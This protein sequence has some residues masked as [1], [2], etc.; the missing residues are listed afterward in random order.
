MDDKVLIKHDDNL[1]E[2]IVRKM[3]DLRKS[4]RKVAVV[5]LEHPAAVVDMTLAAL[6]ERAGVSE[7][8]AIR[9]CA[10]I[11]CNGFRDMRVRLA[12]SLAFARSSSHM[13]VAEDD[14]LQTLITKI[15]DY[16][17]AS[18]NWAQGRLDLQKVGAA[19]EI[20]SEARR[21][22]FFGFGASGIVA[23]D[24]Q[25]KFPLFDTPCG[26]TSD[27]HQMFMTAGM[28]GD[29]DVVVAI[30]NTGTTREVVQAARIAQEN[31]AR[32]IGIT[33]FQSA[34]VRHCDVA[35]IVETLENTDLYT[36]TV[37]RLAHLVI[38]DILSTAV[39]L[40]R[41]ESHHRRLSGMKGGLAKLRA[42]D[43]DPCISYSD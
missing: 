23:L 12:R 20:L 25:Q 30:S 32:V 21:I 6:A 5:V 11:G 42:A 13:A 38:I 14:D 41:G 43:G 9:F 7:P 33:G 3:P 1:L 8:T 28:M 34:L 36:P 26:A 2:L 4:D 24:A 39:S 37:S 29:G 35:L 31:S 27:A 40:K 22:E 19:V 18:L 17:L 16:N 15:F 10:A